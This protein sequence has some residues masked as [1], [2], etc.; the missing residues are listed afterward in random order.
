MLV[1]L[2]IIFLRLKNY[3]PQSMISAGFTPIVIENLLEGDELRT[4]VEA[5]EQAI[6]RVG[7]E[8]VLCVHTTTSCFAPRVPERFVQVL[9]FSS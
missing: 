3:Y 6:L 9:N 5:I 4:D 8:Q 1:S 2:K 7:S